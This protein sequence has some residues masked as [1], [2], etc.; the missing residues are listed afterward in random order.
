METVVG[1]V[2]ADASF[3]GYPFVWL[4][5]VGA[6]HRRR[7]IATALMRHAES[8]FPPGKR[9]TSTN[10]SNLGSQRLLESLGYRRS[11]LIENLDEGDPEIIYYK[12]FSAT[13]EG[14]RAASARGP[15]AGTEVTGDQMSPPNPPPKSP[16][17]KSPPKSPPPVSP[18]KSAAPT[19]AAFPLPM[20]PALPA[21]A[22]P[23]AS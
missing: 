21:S 11:G 18:P 20:S 15:A 2:V 5:V 13:D 1:Y 17:P 16:P 10:E 3:F 9:F 7:G 4:V 22:G 8:M 14:T 6:A 23:E 12:V 19:S